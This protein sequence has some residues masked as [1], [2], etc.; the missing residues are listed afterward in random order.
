MGRVTRH[1]KRQAVW[2]PNH[3]ADIARGS[4]RVVVGREMGGTYVAPLWETGAMKVHVTRASVAAG[5]DEKTEL[6]HPAD[7]NGGGSLLLFSRESK[8]RLNDLTVRIPAD[9]YTHRV[10][11]VADMA[12]GAAGVTVSGDSGVAVSRQ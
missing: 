1:H 3:G 9:G 6:L 2:L 7:A 11:S 4:R 12:I 10:L 8:K 5:D